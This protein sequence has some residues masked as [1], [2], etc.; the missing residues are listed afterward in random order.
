[1]ARQRAACPITTPLAAG[2]IAFSLSLP[3]A[4]TPA[5]A[6]AQA[7]AAGLAARDRA[8]FLRVWPAVQRCSADLNTVTGDL[9]Q[10]SANLGA[11]HAET[12]RLGRDGTQMR[13][14]CL[15]AAAR[16]NR[17]HFAAGARHTPARRVKAELHAALVDMAEGASDCTQIAD[18]IARGAIGDV[19][20]LLQ[21]GAS[22]WQAAA[23]HMRVVTSYVH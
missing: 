16:V 14:D 1:M 4:A 7:P 13:N 12:G 18:D 15:A 2:L 21:R 17:L 11:G 19:V 10:V 23:A 22:A 8:A 6:H 20:V 9:Q 3:L 5:L